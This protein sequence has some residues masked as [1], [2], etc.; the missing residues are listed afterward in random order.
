MSDQL[1]PTARTPMTPAAVYAALASAWT[2]LLGTQPTR[3]E[4]LV[5][6]SQWA[7]ETG[8]GAASDNWNLAGIQHVQGDGHDYAEYTS[9]EIIN[10]Q[11]VTKV[12]RF[13]AYAT[14][15][16]SAAD[17]LRTLRKDFGFAWPAVEAGDVDDFGHRLKI[18][19]YY[20]DTEAVYVAGLERWRASL[21]ASIP[22]DVVGALANGR[23]AVVMP[24]PLSPEVD[25][26]E[27]A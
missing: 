27:V 1:V 16:E 17:Y 11:R 8:G 20:T 12:E 21:D 9:F 4:L 13:R 5:L 7:H 2:A 15:D 10:G 6:L 26:P 24:D 23:P 14:L 22:A 18:R 3:A 25:P 19:A